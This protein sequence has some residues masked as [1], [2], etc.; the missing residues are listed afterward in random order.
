MFIIGE[1]LR[2]CHVSEPMLC[3]CDGMGLL[4]GQ[5]ENS[6]LTMNGLVGII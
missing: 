6:K 1:V 3:R 5:D 2:L 4:F